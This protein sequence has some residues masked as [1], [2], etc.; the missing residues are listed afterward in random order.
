MIKNPIE[1]HVKTVIKDGYFKGKSGKKY[2]IRIDK[3]TTKK[4][5]FFERLSLELAH[6]MS[7]RNIC[8]GIDEI[9]DLT[10]SKMETNEVIRRLH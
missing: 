3:V 9:A 2:F 7:F 4:A 8:K 1:E 6:D 10:G 5:P